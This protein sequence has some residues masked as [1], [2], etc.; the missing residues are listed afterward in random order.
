MVIAHDPDL[1][2]NTGTSA[3][4]AELTRAELATLDAGHGFSADGGASHPWRGRGIRIPTLREAFEALPGVRFNVEVK[5]NDPRLVGGV[6]RLVA[7]HA[8]A[9]RTLLA[10]AEDDTLAAVRAELAR[11]DVPAALGASVGDVIGYVRAAL[12]Q[13]APPR[14]PMALQVPPSFAGRPLVTEQLVAFAHAHDV[15]VHVWTIN[16]ETEMTRL[17]EL[18][19]DGVMSDFPGRLAALVERRR[20]QRLAA[21]AP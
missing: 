18:G 13:G 3:K 12:G 11:Q 14:E 15:Q 4:I 8:R 16:D 7:E 21:S 2:R 10:A 20:A 9:D 5:V 19:V 1:A 17:L 6:V